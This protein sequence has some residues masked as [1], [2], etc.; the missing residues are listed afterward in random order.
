MGGV[1]SEEFT[2]G[3]VQSQSAAGSHTGLFPCWFA[4]GRDETMCP[5]SWEHQ[6]NH[7]LVKESGTVKSLCQQPLRTLL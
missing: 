5:S 2:L 1:E 6:G 4:Q 7:F 3:N